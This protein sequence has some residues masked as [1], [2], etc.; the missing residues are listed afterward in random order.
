MIR[1]MLTELVGILYNEIKHPGQAAQMIKEETLNIIKSVPSP[2][3]FMECVEHIVARIVR[4]LK[5]T[6]DAELEELLLD[7]V[8][9]L[10]WEMRQE[11]DSSNQ[12]SIHIEL[13][14]FKF[15]KSTTLV[16]IREGGVI[17]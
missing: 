2:E 15:R 14:I 4:K 7:N 13:G 3:Q 10:F 12:A 1:S 11:E 17:V 8:A 9:D 6:G 5:K 16:S